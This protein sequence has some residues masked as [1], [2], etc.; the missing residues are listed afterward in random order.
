MR[1][2]NF[3][4]LLVLFFLFVFLGFPTFAEEK[5]FPDDVK[6]FIGNRDACD[7]FRGEPAYSKERYKFLV[8]MM[9][10]TCLGTDKELTRLKKK[11]KKDSAIM[12]KLNIY[13]ENIQA[14]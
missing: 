13:E 2:I 12:N 1:I 14:N 9:N 10:K 7:H 8:E 5:N 6:I 3:L 11:Y 4:S